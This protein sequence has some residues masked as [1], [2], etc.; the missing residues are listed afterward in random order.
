MHYS[1][2]PIV[3]AV[4]DIQVERPGDSSSAAADILA[5]A[6]AVSGSFPNRLPIR[7]MNVSVSADA[8]GQL[9][10]TAE[11]SGVGWRVANEKNDRVLQIQSHAFTYS[12]M[13]PYTKWEVFRGEAEPLW[14]RYVE[15]CRPTKVRR[16]AVRYINRLKLPIG[17][18]E[19]SEYLSFSPDVPK[20]FSPLQ[21]FLMQVQLA[22]PDIAPTAKSVI[23][24]ATEV[25][26]E[27]YTPV[28][29]DFDV[30]LEVDL[31]ANDPQIWT[32]LQ[33]LRDKKNELFEG[34]ITPRMKEMI[35]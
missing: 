13:P 3:E 15:F 23:T 20:T 28:V 6:D 34:S 7:L 29:L 5:Y 32:Y 17:R 22:Q 19:L 10:N 14:T 8:A 33:V 12:H 27:P 2:A 4:I 9:T 21:A 35:K 1:R 18:F 30:F 16:I 11:Q 24:A 31:A 25:P 26:S